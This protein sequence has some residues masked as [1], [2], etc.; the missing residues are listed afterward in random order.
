MSH[1]CAK[2][3]GSL[4]P[5][6]NGTISTFPSDQAIP[7]SVL[8]HQPRGSKLKQQRSLQIWKFGDTDF[9]KSYFQHTCLCSLSLYTYHFP[10]EITQNRCSTIYSAGSKINQSHENYTYIQNKT[11]E[12]SNGLRNTIKQKILIQSYVIHT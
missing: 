4:P 6:G 9:N 2:R 5:I 11:S 12:R 7:T 8:K 10:T 3:K 1:S